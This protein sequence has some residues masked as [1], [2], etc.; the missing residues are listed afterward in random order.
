VKTPEGL[1]LT[2]CEEVLGEKAPLWA[3]RCY[4]I[5]S[6]IVAAG[7]LD[8]TAV[9]GHWL[10]PVHP[11]SP[12]A[13]G[14][15]FV[16]HGWVVFPN[17]RRVLD[18]TRWVFEHEEPYLFLG[19]PGKLYDEGGNEWRGA[20]RGPVPSFDVSEKQ[21]DFDKRVMDTATWKFVERYLE[22]DYMDEDQVPGVL[23]KQQVFW[24]ANAPLA[25]L[26]PHAKTVYDALVKKG[27]EALIPIDNFRRV[28]SGRWTGKR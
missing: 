4:E 16:Q 11:K 3:G 12:F 22:I 13:G 5:S 20:T 1:T 19:D 24:L 26:G 2:D 17:D 18:P 14:R 25:D 10:G 7:L 23:S 21:F 28:M 8:G 9:Y 6:R 27:E 15:P